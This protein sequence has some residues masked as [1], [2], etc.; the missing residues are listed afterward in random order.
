MTS[1]NAGYVTEIAYTRGYYR[2]LTPS[3][4]SFVGLVCGKSIVKLGAPM[5][6]CEL[7][8]GQ[9]LSASIIA[10]ANP[11]IEVHAVDFNPEHIAGARLLADD[12][13][14]A[15]AHFHELAFADLNDDPALTGMFDMITLHGIYSW[16]STNNRSHIVKFIRRRLKP[17]GL[18]YVSYNTLPGWAPVMPLRRLMFDHANLRKGPIAPR[19]SDALAFA[20]DLK[21]A[22]AGYFSQNPA[23]GERLDKLRSMQRIYRA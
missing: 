22:G 7:G 18:V 20:E 6:Y 8:C 9:G 16:I 2:E 19:V 15:N 14:V 3:L 12:G 10:A 21:V 11:Q 13:R 1:W 23:L 17:G 4:L 5:R